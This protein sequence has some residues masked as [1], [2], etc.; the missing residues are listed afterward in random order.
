MLVAQGCRG[1]QRENRQSK[2]RVGGQQSPEVGILQDGPLTSTP[3]GLSPCRPF[4]LK[5][6]KFYLHSTEAQVAQRLFGDIKMPHKCLMNNWECLKWLSLIPLPWVHRACIQQALG[7][8]SHVGKMGW[9]RELRVGRAQEV[10]KWDAELRTG[11][12]CWPFS[13]TASSQGRHLGERAQAEP[14]SLTSVAVGTTMP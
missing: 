5:P 9:P 3:A 12:G 6:L 13:T 8:L 10:A 2:I 14:G 4:C 7:K 11:V 1:C